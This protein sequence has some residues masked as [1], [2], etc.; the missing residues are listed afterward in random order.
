MLITLDAKV[1]ARYPDMQVCGLVVRGVDAAAVDALSFDGWPTPETGRA[2]EVVA[3]WK[4]LHKTL[5]AD[6]HARCSIAWLVKAAATERLRRIHPL[7][8]LYN[9]ASLGSLCPFGGEDI[10]R[11]QGALTLTLAHGQEGFVP[12][13]RPD[14]L[15][16]PGN[17]EVV[18]LDGEDQ[19]V[20][21]ALNW[22]ESDRHKITERTCDVVF[23][24]ERPVPQLPDPQDGMTWLAR[25]LAGAAQR[26][27]A[28]RLDAAH[29]QEDA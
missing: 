4:A 19:V 17:G 23:V 20:C 22:L 9:Q 10:A 11:L 18:W 24:S 29:P 28:F 5:S 27:H 13:G 2:E 25:K 12:L 7:V 14:E 15:Q 8:D 1:L 16:R 26:I 3:H 6:K 21:R